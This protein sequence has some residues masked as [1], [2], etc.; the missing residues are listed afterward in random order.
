MWFGELSKLVTGEVRNSALRLLA[1]SPVTL[2]SRSPPHER[3]DHHPRV[4]RRKEGSGNQLQ[5]QDGN[6]CL[7]TFLV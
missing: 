3:D 1:D 4:G 7:L 2:R 5:I 6:P